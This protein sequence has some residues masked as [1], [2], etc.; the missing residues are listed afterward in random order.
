MAKVN[1]MYQTSLKQ[2]LNLFDSSIKNSARGINTEERIAFVLNRLNFE[3][4]QFVQ[5]LLFEKDRFL[6]T[7]LMTLKIHLHSE[8]ITHEE[9][10]VL[11]K[12]MRTRNGGFDL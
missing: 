8:K 1:F 9:F 4:W 2:F 3:V 6:F 5:R 12:G 7:L 11:I 10:M